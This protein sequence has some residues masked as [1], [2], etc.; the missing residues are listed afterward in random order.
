M[1]GPK[2]VLALQGDLKRS[3]NCDT[4]AVEH[5]AMTQVPNAMLEVFSAS[6]RTAQG[7]LEILEKTDTAS[8]PKP[9][10]EVQPKDVDLSTG[11]PSKTT[12]IGAGLGYK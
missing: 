4:E 7:E 5:A 9:S 11:N 12:M 2:G 3:Y 1:P 8:K 10:E 6:K